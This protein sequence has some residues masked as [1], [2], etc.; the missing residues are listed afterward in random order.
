MTYLICRVIVL[1]ETDGKPDVMEINGEPFTSVQ[2]DTIG[3][4]VNSNKEQVV[5]NNKFKIKQII[6]WVVYIIVAL[7]V[8]VPPIVMGAIQN[9]SCFTD[10]TK[11]KIAPPVWLITFGCIFGLGMITLALTAH[12]NVFHGFPKS[13]CKKCSKN[14]VLVTLSI[15]VFF[16]M[17]VWSFLGI[18]G[19]DANKSATL[20]CNG[21]ALGMETGYAT[22]GL[23]FFAIFA[24][25]LITIAVLTPC[26]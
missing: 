13:C 14:V 12:H 2:V 6:F 19:T 5:N 26:S 22:L 23:I 24:S 15:V 7:G 4:Q 8:V 9:T 10:C 20:V 3:K 16:G 1:M 25:Y 11:C 21:V 18:N 17:F